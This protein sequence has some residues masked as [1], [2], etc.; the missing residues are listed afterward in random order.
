MQMKLQY[1]MLKESNIAEK[2]TFPY[3]YISSWEKLEETQLPPF[4]AFYD[5]LEEQNVTSLK[6]YEKAQ[7]MFTAFNC[8]TLF[9]YQL[10]YGIRL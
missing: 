2:G 10:R 4:D 1:P 8:K 9:D 3:S 7:E 6:D 5:E